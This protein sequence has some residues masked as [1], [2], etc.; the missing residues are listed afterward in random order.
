MAKVKVSK[1]GITLEVE[2]IA[3]DYY[4]RTGYKVRK[5][6]KPAPAKPA[7]IKVQL[8]EP[9]RPAITPQPDYTDEELAT[10]RS[11]LSEVPAVTE[12]APKRKAQS[13]TEKPKR[14]PRRK[15]TE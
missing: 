14:K 11:I 4:L 12:K 7:V 6:P 8:I 10:M 13:Q 2:E 15:K 3:V 1:G 5:A 9:E